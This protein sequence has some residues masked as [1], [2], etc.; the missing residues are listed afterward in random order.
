MSKDNLKNLINKID[1]VT[2][3]DS[4]EKLQATKSVRLSTEILEALNKDF[5]IKNKYFQELRNTLKVIRDKEIMTPKDAEMIAEGFNLVT[6]ELK[7][8]QDNDKQEEVLTALYA[9]KKA[10][11]QIDI[12]KEVKVS[13]IEEGVTIKN[14]PDTQKVE[15]K[16]LPEP[17][18]EVAVKNFPKEFKVEVK[19]FPEQ[20]KVEKIKVEVVNEVKVK[21]PKWYV[22]PWK[23]STFFNKL[24]EMWIRL[25]RR[26]TD[27][28]VT[29]TY[30]VEADK[31]KN[32][33][34]AL[35]V[36]LVDKKGEF[37]DKIIPTIHVS[38][39]GGGGGGGGDASWMANVANQETMIDL[40]QDIKT[41]TASITVHIDSLTVE[42]DET[43]EL[44]G[45]NLVEQFA[46]ATGVASGSEY[47]LIS[48]TVPALTAPLTKYR[49]KRV[50]CEGNRDGIFR[51][52]VN[53][54]K[55]W[56]SRNAWTQRGVGIDM[57][58]D[59]SPGDVITLK[60]YHNNLLAS[61]YSGRLEIYELR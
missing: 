47:T 38:P 59:A 52:Y 61:D 9:V 2:G 35:A 42:L 3:E 15:V 24:E 23:M 54:T 7:E 33:K 4:K 43:E 1:E 20:Q 45:K 58:I 57:N 22:K 51:I 29:T 21:E 14:F 46:E 39:P 50:F 56:Q 37:I 44:L 41:N 28:I 60:V 31:H 6:D 32:P 25:Q 19:N 40:L 27:R 8:I 13:N 16:N 48:I 11:S 49:I 5:E 55:K 26:A 12:P 18:E 17:V 36:R 34:E 53:S 30:E 10:I